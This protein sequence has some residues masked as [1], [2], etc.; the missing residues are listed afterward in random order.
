MRR[1]PVPIVVCGLALGLA[2]PSVGGA[3]PSGQASALRARQTTLSDRSHS[4]LLSLYSLDTRLTRARAEVASLRA[5]AAAIRDA[6]G[7]ATEEE[8]LAQDGWRKSV[9]ALGARLR[10]LYEQSQPDT[11]GVL[12][13]ATSIDDAVARLDGLRASARMDRDT[14]AQAETAARMLAALRNKLAAQA[15][16]VS[17]LQAQ[18]SQTVGALAAAR[19]QRLAYLAS[20]ARQR[21]FNA[22]QIVRLDSTARKIAVHSQAISTQPQPQAAPTAP[23]AAQG[24]Q[25]TVIATGYSMVGHTATGMPVGWG[26]VAVDPSVI[27]LGTRLSIP[28][29]G[30]GVAADTGSAVQGVTIDLWFP[31]PAQALGWG[32]RTVTIT[33]H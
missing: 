22:K 31:T 32:R 2:V 24:N 17:L 19:T 23:V 18:T 26:V 12:L 21:T 1:A 11:L 5:R 30:E 33:L 6:R 15:R 8:A 28:G 7:Q 3:D 10:V 16:Q 27:P 9:R 25:L 13:G 29:Y 4:A 14:I 20:L